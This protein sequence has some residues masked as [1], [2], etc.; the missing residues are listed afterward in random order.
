MPMKPKITTEKTAGAGKKPAGKR[1]V[2]AAALLALLLAVYLFYGNTALTV[3]RI[4]IHSAKLPP[5]FDGFTIAQV[6][7]LHNCPNSLLTDA[8]AEAIR[9]AQPDAI[10]LTGD[11]IDYGLTDVDAA[12]KVIDKLLA[13]APIYYVT[14]NHE[15]RT[16]EYYR[17]SKTLR[18]MGVTELSDGFVT[19]RLHDDEIVIA[20]INDPLTAHEYA[21]P[22]RVI[23]ENRLSALTYNRDMYT[24]LLSHRP[25]LMS[26]YA[27]FGVDLVFTGHAHGGL[28]RLPF[29]GGLFA[30]HQGFFPQYD[31]GVYHSGSTDMIV[32][33]GI[34]NSGRSLRIN[35]NPE[36]ILAVLHA[37]AE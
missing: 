3:T 17:L 33:R 8:L 22:D 10:F 25:E 27:T 24:I 7:D 6:S 26:T 30:P 4:D 35:D 11:V 31:G 1:L 2:I 29:I 28:I 37:G 32:S 16:G 12:V 9:E 15:A 36:L 19:V 23:A 21:V 13:I 14:G 18:K 5:E 20:G 34:G